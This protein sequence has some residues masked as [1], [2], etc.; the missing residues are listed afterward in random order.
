MRFSIATN[1]C[2]LV[3]YVQGKRVRRRLYIVMPCKPL[4]PGRLMAAWKVRL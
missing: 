3:H 1:G 2:R 4:V